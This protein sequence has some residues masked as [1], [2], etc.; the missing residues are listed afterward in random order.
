MVYGVILVYSLIFSLIL[1]IAF[2]LKKHVATTETNIYT[3]LI[4]VNLIGILL[5]L[6]CLIIGQYEAL[7]E[8]Q[9]YCIYA[10]LIYIMVYMMYM[11]L[12]V[13]SVCYCKKEDIYKKLKWVT[14]GI[15]V[16][17]ALV[18]IFSPLEIHITYAVG[19]AVDIV[20]V[21]GFL[22]LLSWIL[23]FFLNIQQANYK[24]FFPVFLLAIMIMILS[25]VQKA[26]PEVTIIT[27][28]HFIAVFIMYHTIENP[29]EKVAMVEKEAKQEAERANQ[30]KSE[31]LASMSHELRTPLNAIIGLSED[32][33]SY[34]NNLNQEIQ[35]DSADI[36][37][38]SNTLLELIGNILDI[39]KIESGKLEIVDTYYDPREEIESLT[40]IMRTKVAEKPIE[41]IVNISNNM[42]KV[43]YGD[44]LRIKQIVNNFLSNAVKYTEKGSITLDVLW[45]DKESKISFKVTDTGN[46]IKKEDLDKVF[47]K[48]ER[49]QVEKINTVQGTGLGLAITKNLVELM[50]GEI[51]VYSVYGQGTTFYAVI[52]QQI[53]SLLEL[54]KL[55]QLSTYKP[56]D[57]SAFNGKKILI[58]DDNQLN[59]KVLRKA[60]KAY[61]F[62]IDECYN[63]KECIDKIDAGNTYDLILLDNLMPIMN[64]EET[65]KVL[66]SKPNFNTHVLALT[67]DAMTGAKEKYMSLGFDDYLAKPFTRD[68]ISQ[69]L[70]NIFEIKSNVIGIGPVEEVTN[71]NQTN[72]TTI[73]I[74][75]IDE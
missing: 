2:F 17:F 63:G 41:L 66:K 26:N 3:K 23:V 48:F 64:G 73:G 53:G 8:T 38:A 50:N 21:Y 55:Q 37:N 49:L 68:A 4:V 62:I 59:I 47:G 52:P 36:V 57:M 35:D 25:F 22:L 51:G 71:N 75:P 12:Y 11:S 70:G 20:Y 46:G 9:K 16:I 61:N 74:G 69:K 28:I 72:D 58:V 32:I 56:V 44:R 54:S 30:A 27:A 34:K 31:F 15:T 18:T 10:Y 39:S 60:I 42:P 7:R 5:E 19:R 24:K 43:L 13:Y 33:E 6:T 1:N 40:K 45:L 29:D 67:A 65:I 14:I